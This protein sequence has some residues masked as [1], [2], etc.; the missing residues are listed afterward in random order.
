MSRGSVHGVVSPAKYAASQA[1]ATAAWVVADLRPI[2]PGRQIL[3]VVKPQAR[4]P[5]GVTAKIK[6]AQRA[7]DLHVDSFRA[8]FHI[9]NLFSAR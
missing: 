1:C 3:L 4:R 5:R 8:E 6:V 7:A 2:G 9:K